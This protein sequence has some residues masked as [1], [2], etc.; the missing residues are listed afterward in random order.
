LPVC[1]SPTKGT[2]PKSIEWLES[3]WD[4]HL[5]PFF[6]DFQASRI[7]TEKLVEYRNER[8]KADVSPSTV[9]KELMVLGAM[10]RHGLENYTPPKIS[11]IPKFPAKLAESSPPSGF[12][13]DE[14]YDALQQNC[15]HAWLRALLALAFT[16]GF[17]R[18]ELVGGV[19]RNQS[20]MRVN[21]MDLKNRTTLLSLGE[22]KNNEGRV[23]KMTQEV[24]DLL[25]ICV[26]GKVPTDAVFTGENGP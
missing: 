1:T 25:R 17:R 5:E 13:T 10:F 24:Y 21:Q 3:V 22:T 18:S 14:Q 20:G 2:A 26:E 8:I 7:T 12:L 4:N 19:Q 11:R 16:Y 6:G 23:V 15:K 9:N